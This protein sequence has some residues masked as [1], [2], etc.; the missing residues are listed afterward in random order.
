M[1]RNII[2]ISHGGGPLPL[3]GDKK[4]EEMVTELKKLSSKI[5]RP[6][7]IIVISAHWEETVA[8][9]TSASYPDIIYDYYGFPEESYSIK[10]PS[11]GDPQLA[12]N[13]YKAMCETGIE[14]RMD[15]D[16]GFDHGLYVPLKIMYP[17]ADIPCIQLSLIKGLNPEAHLALGE[18]LKS[19][20]AENL[21]IVGSGFSF[22]NMRAF[23]EAVTPETKAM[24]EEFEEWL[25]ETCSSGELSADD[26]YQRLAEW[27]N[28]PSAR[29]CHPREEHLMP[30]H[31]A[32]GAAGFKCS[33]YAELY[34]LGRKSSLFI[35]SV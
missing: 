1:N 20:D 21:L 11:P 4:H 19:V 14:C 30:L 24:N 12:E 34:I 33:Y 7:A 27:E 22:H 28:A 16:R 35:W 3:L 23:F 13:V 31:V 9:V 32:Y 17:E 18:A 5:E 10:Y 26:R 25:I 29:Y 2:Y 6:S 15:A 8:T